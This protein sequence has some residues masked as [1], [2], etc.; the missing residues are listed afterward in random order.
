MIKLFRDK[1]EEL[2]KETTVYTKYSDAQVKAFTEYYN[3][4]LKSRCMELLD[5]INTRFACAGIDVSEWK[6]N[7]DTF[8]KPE[9]LRVLLCLEMMSI[10]LEDEDTASELKK[11]IIKNGGDCVVT[12]PLYDTKDEEYYK[13]GMFVENA[14]LM[15]E[16]E[17][18][19]R[20]ALKNF[21]IV[22]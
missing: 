1:N 18:H 5:I 20:K 12:F 4:S 3:R 22:Q 13:F 21:G 16:E 9:I 10:M 17:T 15:S 8:D 2:K 11:E 6:I 14:K 7:R 19:M